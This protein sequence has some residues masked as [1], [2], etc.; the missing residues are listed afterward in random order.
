MG[1]IKT[2]LTTEEKLA[3]TRADLD[4]IMTAGS[5]EL[6][7]RAEQ[8]WTLFWRNP[9][10][11]TCQEVFDSFGTH[12]LSMAQLLLQAKALIEKIDPSIW[13][14]ERPG[15]VTPVLVDGQPNG[16]VM[17]TLNA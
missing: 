7:F 15:T 14:L 17:V 16:S 5:R 12:A 4:K 3:R 11:L 10:G 6:Y 2:D 9:Q 1:L 8:V 13:Q